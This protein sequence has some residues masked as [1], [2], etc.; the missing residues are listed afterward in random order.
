MT[1]KDLE[2]KIE[3]LQKQIEELENRP[4]TYIVPYVPY[5]PYTPY[6]PYPG[7]VPCQNGQNS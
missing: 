1:T 2:K 7:I 4:V 3:D 6:M 5:T